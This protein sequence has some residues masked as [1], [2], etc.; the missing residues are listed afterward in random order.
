MQKQTTEKRLSIQQNVEVG[1][2]QK[3]GHWHTFASGYAKDKGTA[4][5][6]IEC[7]LTFGKPHSV[8]KIQE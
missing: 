1:D 5:A 3:T 7:I 6:V 8:V 4:K 2:N